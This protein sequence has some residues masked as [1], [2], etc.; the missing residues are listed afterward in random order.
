MCLKFVSGKIF[1]ILKSVD[2]IFML[3][4]GFI[5]GVISIPLEFNPDFNLTLV[6]FTLMISAFLLNAT[7]AL[8]SFTYL[9]IFKTDKINFGD[10]LNNLGYFKIKHQIKE[11]KLFLEKINDIKESIVQKLEEN[12]SEN[13]KEDIL[14]ELKELDN[15]VDD[16]PKNVKR[17]SESLVLYRYKLI[18][19]SGEYFFLSTIFLIIGF[20]FLGS[21][22]FL[23]FYMQIPII[24]KFLIAA[25]IAYTIVAII[26][27]TRGLINS[28]MFFGHVGIIKDS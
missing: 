27:F 11:Y 5:A 28:L 20:F 8:L 19:R 15:V 13:E 21:K 10:D 16:I 23:A 4:L 17:L 7:L 14:H 26:I 24:S 9:L 18:L 6:I 1:S 25:A 12:S 2:M 3:F 22:I